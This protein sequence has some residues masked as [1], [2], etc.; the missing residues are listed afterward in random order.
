MPVNRL[1]EFLED[2]RARYET[3]EHSPAVAATA[4]AESVHIAERDFAKTVILKI[5][6]DLAMV[7]LPANRRILLA[8]FREVLGESEIHLAKEN[9]F[10]GCFPECELGAM[11]PFGNLYD[12]P[13]IVAP[14]LAAEP[15]IAF[16]AG[17][18]REVIK[19]PFSEYAAAARP[20]I[21]AFPTG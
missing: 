18:H 2:R 21:M 4:V 17:T 1:K 13:V 5:D 16:N 12:M 14:S 20:I 9:E 7:V 11:P 10:G 19:M 3:V 15:E 8:A 6:G